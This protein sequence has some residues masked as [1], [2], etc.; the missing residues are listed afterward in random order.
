MF[1]VIVKKTDI[2]LEVIAGF[3]LVTMM[4]LTVS[5]VILRIFG[6]PIPGTYE[7]VSF[8]GTILIGFAVPVVTLVKA[9]VLVDIVVSKLSDRKK[10][11][12]LVATRV[13]SIFL[14]LAI[15]W[16]L[17]K[18]AFVMRESGEV[19]GTLQIPFYPVAIG[20]GIAFFVVSLTLLAELVNL[21]P[22][23]LR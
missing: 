3:A 4:L 17:I 10:T 22:K 8:M 19:S 6:Y 7:L 11:S 18:M 20:L 23:G 13:V 14:T 2:V 5:D 21:F 16:N 15:G 12:F 1:S 9:H